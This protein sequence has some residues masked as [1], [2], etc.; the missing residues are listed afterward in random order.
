M[1]SQETQESSISA[2]LPKR[3]KRSGEDAVMA[4]TM[5]HRVCGKHTCEPM[6]TRCDGD[7]LDIGGATRPTSVALIEGNGR[8]GRRGTHMSITGLEVF[9]MML[10]RRRT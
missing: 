6:T 7:G 3:N 8:Q 10:Q 5:W 9:D 2:T 1:M 4:P